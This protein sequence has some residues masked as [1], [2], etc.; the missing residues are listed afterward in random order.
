[1]NAAA[2]HFVGLSGVGI[3]SA[4][5]EFRKDPANILKLG[6]FGY[7]DA[8]SLKSI[9]RGLS[10]TALMIQVPYDGT[11]AP[12]AWMAG[13]GS[14]VRGVPE[15]RSIQPFVSTK[16]NGQRGTMV[17]MADGSVRFVS[18]NVSDAVFQAM[19]T[20]RGGNPEGFDL[21]KDAPVVPRPRENAPPAPSAEATPPAPPATVPGNG[22]A[23]KQLDEKK[24]EK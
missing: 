24:S 3:D 15:K 16:F 22:E 17:L 18:E 7:D 2:T 6:V 9:E 21:N 23:P 12:G 20:V 14:T 1:M 4:D 13:G 5:A 10:N 8:M 19:V 11:A